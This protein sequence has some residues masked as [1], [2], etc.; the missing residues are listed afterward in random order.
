MRR[1]DE[2][3]PAGSGGSEAEKLAS[4]LA[5]LRDEAIGLAS[6]ATALFKAESRLFASS[7]VQIGVLLVL[8]AAIATGLVGLGGAGLAW[9]LVEQFGL[10]W[11]AAFFAV[12]GFLLL[13]A[14]GGLYW[15]W[16]LV[17]HLQFVETRRMLGLLPQEQSQTKAAMEEDWQP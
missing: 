2:P 7:L 4:Q 15:I 3:E 1:P 6:T 16:A 9:L 12:V 13:V 5:G 11:A 17:R 14:V 8:L 10:S